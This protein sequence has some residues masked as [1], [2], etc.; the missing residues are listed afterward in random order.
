MKWHW[1]I[2]AFIVLVLS[3]SESTEKDLSN[4]SDKI[5]KGE[6]LCSQSGLKVFE[7]YIR[8]EFGDSRDI[9]SEEF[10]IKKI[11]SVYCEKDTLTYKVIFNS[12]M[13]NKG[14]HILFHRYVGSQT[15]F[16]FNWK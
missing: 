9:Y 14:W 7:M 5:G 8:E 16:R 13:L 15:L 3:C 12:D 1:I 10:I 2:S 4:E 11:D 6:N